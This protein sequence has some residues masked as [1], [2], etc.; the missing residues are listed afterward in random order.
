MILSPIVLFTYKRFDTLILTI[1]KLSNNFLAS[2]SELFIFSDGPKNDFDVAEVS[3][4]RDYLHS[5]T[6]FKSVKVF[7]SS[8]NKGLANSIISGVTKMF[9]NYEK[10]IVLEDDLITSPNFLDYM[11]QGLEFYCNYENVLSICGYSQLINGIFSFDSYF[12][13]RSSS[14]GWA[15]WKKKWV[16]VDWKFSDYDSFSSNRIKMNDFNSMGSDL[17]KLLR[18]QKYGIINSWAIR[19]NFHQFQHNYYS[20]HP[21]I[22]KV[23]N[24]GFNDK[25]AENTYT[26][27]IRFKTVLDSSQNRKFNF[28]VTPFI[29]KKIASQFVKPFSMVNRL[30]NKFISILFTCKFK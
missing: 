13:H 22:S 10:V 21:A 30:Y 28:S 25:Y 24:L 15:T 7:E 14:W 26:R 17:F 16:D 19:F 18:N 12:T 11:N 8:F 6:G 20:V 27:N 4:V 3:K 1:D 29:D 5:I 9:E 23:I 2:E